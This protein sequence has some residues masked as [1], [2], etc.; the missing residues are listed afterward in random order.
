MRESKGCGFE[1][2]GGE[3]RKYPFFS[4]KEEEAVRVI[5]GRIR[6]DRVEKVVCK[7]LS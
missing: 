6:D 2:E 5:E 1:F 7:G 4:T 3:Q